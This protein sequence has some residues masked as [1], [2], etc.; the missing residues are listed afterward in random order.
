MTRLLLADDD[1]ELCQ[2]LNEYLSNEGFD[3]SLAHDGS[4]A[5]KSILAQDF[6]LMILDVMLPNLN[7]FEVLKEVRK[8]SQ[9][10]ILMLTARGDEI[11]RIVGL[12]LGADDYIGKP[13]N[14]RELTA[15]IRSILRRTENIYKNK[16]QK[17]ESIQLSDVKINPS[18]REVLQNDSPVKLTATEFDI[19]YLL[20]SHAGHLVDR[21]QLSEQCLGRKLEPYDRSIDMHISNLR[22]KLGP[23]EKDD[24]RI[25]TVRGVGYQYVSL[26]S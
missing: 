8:E 11:D 17:L 21:D 2:L 7:G 13:C 26:D 10:P 23:N 5:A 15:R 22:K 16:N 1:I 18:A 24:D 6:D 12:E 9:V 14:P 3:I 25:K 19:L 20:I 4:T